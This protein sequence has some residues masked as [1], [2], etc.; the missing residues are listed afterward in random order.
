MVFLKL[1][2]KANSPKRLKLISKSEKPPESVFHPLFWCGKSVCGSL[3]HPLCN[4]KVDPERY[5]PCGSYPLL[6]NNVAHHMNRKQIIETCRLIQSIGRNVCHWPTGIYV[7]YCVFFVTS[8]YSHLQRSK[9]QVINN[10]TLPYIKGMKGKR[11]QIF[12][13]SQKWWGKKRCHMDTSWFL[14]P[15]EPSCCA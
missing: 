13:F 11:S 14:G 1:I 5:G 12:N 4:L 3:G 8:Y 2:M 9:I 10:K 6:V 15:Q 7:P